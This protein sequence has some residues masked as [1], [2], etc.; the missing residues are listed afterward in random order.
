MIYA[1]GTP[2]PEMGDKILDMVSSDK[3][4]KS[5]HY[6]L[7][8]KIID[9]EGYDAHIKADTIHKKNVQEGLDLFSKHFQDLWW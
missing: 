6:A 5:G 8:I 7:D 1:F 2:E 4:N 9:Q 3:P